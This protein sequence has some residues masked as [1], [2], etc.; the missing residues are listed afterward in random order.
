MVNPRQVIHAI[1]FAMSLSLLWAASAA[2]ASA[3]QD[4]TLTIPG[5][6]HPAAVN[7]G[8]TAQADIDLQPVGSFAGPVTLTCVVTSQSGSTFLPTCMASPSPAVPPAQPSLT[9]TTLNDTPAGSYQIAVTGTSGSSTPQTAM[10][11]LG[12]TPLSGDYTL[13]VSPTTA[14]P[15]PINA[16]LTATTLVTVTPIGS[17]TGSVTLSCFSVSPVVSPEP[18]CSFQPTNGTGPVLVTSGTPA[19]ATLTI[20]TDGPV[21]TTTRWTPRIFYAFLLAVPGM[22][23]VG[24]GGTRNRGR[25]LMGMFLLLGLAGSVLLMPSCGSSTRTNNPSGLTTPTNTYTFTL[26]G[27]DQNG[28]GPSNNNTNCGTGGTQC[29]AATVSLTVD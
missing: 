20:T 14:T 16:G 8:D 10:V 6:L 15:S 13:S 11:T 28:A 18:F 23:L 4:F 5:G 29:N 2:P 7:P 1:V 19:T 24:V 9:V 27:A 17:Y 12:V 21:P 25:R 3:Q 26:S 22:A